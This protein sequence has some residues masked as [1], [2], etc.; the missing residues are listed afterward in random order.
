MYCQL[1]NNLATYLPITEYQQ[2]QTQA[3]LFHWKSQ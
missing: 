1:Y 2:L 3:N